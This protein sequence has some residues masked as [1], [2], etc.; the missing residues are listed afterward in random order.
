MND[1]TLKI[2]LA[3]TIAAYLIY[4]YFFDCRM[5]GD[6]RRELIRLKSLRISQKLNLAM[7]LIVTVLNCYQPLNVLTVLL[8]VIITTLSTEI[9]AKTYFNNTM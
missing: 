2:I 1:L 6:E 3:I 5:V 8:V 7:L 9:A 4:L